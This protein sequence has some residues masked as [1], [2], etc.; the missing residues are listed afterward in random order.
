MTH[1]HLARHW[2]FTAAVVA[3]VFFMGVRSCSRVHAWE[4]DR[5]RDVAIGDVV[6]CVGGT[7]VPRVR[8][9]KLLDAD[10]ALNLAK[11]EL[12]ECA[13]QKDAELTRCAEKSAIDLNQCRTERDSEA[14]ARRECETRVTEPK[15]VETRS[16]ADSPYFVGPVAFVLGVGLTVLVVKVVRD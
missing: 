16:W 11:T 1:G 4:C 8:L 15:A 2:R 5:F 12:A 3:F 10:S 14:N 13:V 9:S 6:K 7:W